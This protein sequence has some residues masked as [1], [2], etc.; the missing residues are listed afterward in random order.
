MRAIAAFASQFSPGPD[1]P[2][3]FPLDRFRE[4]VELAAR[5]Q[6]QRIHVRYG[7]AFVIREPL[8]VQDLW[9]LGGSTF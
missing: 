4:N 7:E 2:L 3:G 8:E 6:G 1:E 5:R 9:A